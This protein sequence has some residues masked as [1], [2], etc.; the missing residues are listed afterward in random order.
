MSKTHQTSEPIDVTSPKKFKG[1]DDSKPKYKLTYFNYRWLAEPA[2]LIL[3]YV[4][5]DF[6]DIRLTQ[7]EWDKV[8]AGKQAKLCNIFFSGTN[9]NNLITLW[10]IMH[11]QCVTR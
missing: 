6:E 4:E 7:E 3:S 1:G 10:S 8:K 9:K 5:E 11:I 2:R